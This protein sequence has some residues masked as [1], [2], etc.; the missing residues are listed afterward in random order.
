MYKSVIFD[1]DGTLCDTGEGIKKSAKYALEAFGMECE[2]PDELDF[3]IGPPLLLVFQEHY[4]VSA[5]MAEDLVKKYRERYTNTGLYEC[6]LYDGIE[7]LLSALK[8]DG[9]LVGIASSKPLKYIELLLD[10]FNIRNY[11]DAVCGVDFK[12]DCEPKTSIIARCIEELKVAPEEALIVGDRS[13][14]V[15]G[16]RANN[17]DAAGV[18]WGYGTKFEFIECSAKFIVEK[19]EDIESIALGLYEQ[20][21]SVTGIYS[22]RIITVHNDEVMLCNGKTAEREC[23]DHPGGVAVIGITDDDEILLVR[24]FRYPYKETIYEI[25]AGKVEKDEDPFLTGVREF[26]EECGAVADNFFSLGEIYPSPGYTSEVIRLYGATGIHIE[27][28]KL[29]EDEFLEVRK[30]KLDVIID[31]IM[32]GEIK[33]AKTVAATFKLKELLSRK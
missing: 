29:D 17:I 27:E 5:S 2:S 16:A 18:L 28:Q 8:S 31:K 13:Y 7:K 9:V 26:K 24:Q 23:V 4:G 6:E 10:K 32:S 15:D 25:P 1:F 14:D 19:P 12:T 21:E 3:F 33:D 30:M 20:T 22:G 11:F